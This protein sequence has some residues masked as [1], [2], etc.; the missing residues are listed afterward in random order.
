VGSAKIV[1]VQ[2]RGQLPKPGSGAELS[3]GLGD[4]VPEKLKGFCNLCLKFVTL[5]DNK[6]SYIGLHPAVRTHVKYCV[7]PV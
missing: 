7:C 3:R 2:G 6:I 4:E 1:R 5:C